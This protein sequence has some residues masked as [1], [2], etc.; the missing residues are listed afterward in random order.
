MA[1]DTAVANVPSVTPS[2]S[3]KEQAKFLAM[4]FRTNMVYK[5]KV[6]KNAAAPPKK[7]A[8]PLRAADDKVVGEDRKDGWNG[9]LSEVA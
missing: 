9:G 2:N 5:G 8:M 6:S 4:L 1:S 3:R 7:P